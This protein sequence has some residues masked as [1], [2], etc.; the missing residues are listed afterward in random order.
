MEQMNSIP[1]RENVLMTAVTAVL[2]FCAILL[3]SYQFTM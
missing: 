3:F 1:A 2:Y